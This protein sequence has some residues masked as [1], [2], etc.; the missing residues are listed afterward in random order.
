MLQGITGNAGLAANFSADY[1]WHPSAAW[2]LTLGPRV[3]IANALYASDYF[4]AQNAK[5]TGNYVPFHAEGG[6][7]PPAR[8]SDRQIRF[9]QASLDEILLR[10]Q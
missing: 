4:A 7:C 3:Q 2:T 9:D 10:F 1:I 5:M 8:E 6:V